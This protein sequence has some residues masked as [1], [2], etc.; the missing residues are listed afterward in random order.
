[1]GSFTAFRM[2]YKEKYV[3]LSVSEI[4]HDQRE[5][6]I[7]CGNS[8]SRE[9]ASSLRFLAMTVKQISLPPSGEVAA[10]PPIGDK[11]RVILSVSEISH[12]TSVKF[13]LCGNPPSREFTNKKS[14]PRKIF[15]GG[16]FLYGV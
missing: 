12:R 7:L 15:R 1:M 3:I 2:T 11:K 5:K 9:I 10:T 14:P 13:I 16:D 8:P 4:S 6:Y